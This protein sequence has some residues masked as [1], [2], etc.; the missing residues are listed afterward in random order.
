MSNT[1][2]NVEDLCISFDTEAGPLSVLDHVNF[3]I[4]Q[5]STVGLVGESGCGKSVTSLSIMRLLPQPAG[6]ITSGKIQFHDKD[7]ATLSPS[8]MHTIRGNKIATA[9]GECTV[10]GKIV[11]SA[12]LM[13]MLA[14]ATD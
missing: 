8:E 1:I 10:G 5:G 3:K 2:L 4:K 14:D 13:F 7:L 6:Q 9:T 12:E 11:S